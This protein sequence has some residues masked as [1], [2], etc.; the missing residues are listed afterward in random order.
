MPAVQVNLRLL[1]GPTPGITSAADMMLAAVASAAMGQCSSPKTTTG[2][3]VNRALARLTDH[4]QV[5]H[6]LC[7]HI[8]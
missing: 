6:D 1:M 2:V 5:T 8:A 4:I 7:R 3:A